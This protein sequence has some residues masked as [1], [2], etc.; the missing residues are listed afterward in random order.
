MPMKKLV[1]YNFG[2]VP[3]IWC[4]FHS[5]NYDLNHCRHGYLNFAETWQKMHE[6]INI[7]RIKRTESEVSLIVTVRKH[8]VFEALLNYN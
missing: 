5:S 4:R 7:I 6:G 8:Y 1:D 2:G 3:V